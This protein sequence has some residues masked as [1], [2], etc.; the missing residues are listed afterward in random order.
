MDVSGD[1]LRMASEARAATR[2]LSARERERNEDREVFASTLNRATREQART[3]EQEA[4]EAAEGLVSAAF[5]QPLLKRI[6]ESTQAAAPFG[7]GKG[8]QTMRSMLDQAWADQMVRYGDWPLVDRV[9][10]RML[11]KL[12]KGTRAQVQPSVTQ[13]ASPASDAANT[14]L[15]A[16]AT[17]T[18][19]QLLR[20]PAAVTD[21][22]LQ[23][24]ARATRLR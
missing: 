2:G 7:P 16:P 6:R 1:M 3:P 18:N 4:R 5:L 13:L 11:E 12:G 9:E 10:Q 17:P 21:L 23:T 20:T 24:P 15:V 22:A 19:T 14:S 8:E